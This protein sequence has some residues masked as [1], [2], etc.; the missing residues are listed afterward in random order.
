[1]YLAR[2]SYKVSTL[3]NI[4]NHCLIYLLMGVSS[5]PV[6]FGNEFLIAGFI[7]TLII[8]YLKTKRFDRVVLTYSLVFL[9][10]FIVHTLA[11][12]QFVLDTFV[13]YFM[14]IYFAYFTVKIIG[15]D[16]D[17]Y[18]IKQIYFFTIISLIVT[19]AIFAYTPL[20]DII[21]SSVTPVFD[22]ITLYKPPEP[23]PHFIIYTMDL[24]YKVELPRNSGPFWEPGGFSVFLFLALTFNVVRTRKIVNTKNIIFFIAIL[25]TQ[26]TTAYLAVFVASCI[27]V[28]ISYRSIYLF[29]V[30]PLLIVIFMNLYTRL[31]FLEEK[32]DKMY[33]ESKKAGTD[34]INSRIVS[35]KVNMD[36]FFSSPL[37]GIGRFFE[38][39]FEDNTGN[40]G[41]TL[42]LA[43]FGL[44]GFVYYF[45]M[46]LLSYKKYCKEHDYNIRF[47]YVVVVGL[48]ILGYS[49]GI[50]QKPFFMALC[51]M[52]L[53]KHKPRELFFYRGLNE[54]LLQFNTS[55]QIVS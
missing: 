22:K 52:F 54:R 23:K 1:M 17:K 15:K 36:N 34:R 7:I 31:T 51:F 47:A 19:G 42:L 53:V 2:E 4:L 25:T 32:I 13:A 20:A 46:M 55:K 14:R 8:F 6:L 40:N 30:M 3:D 48:L 10:L 33:S 21:Y 37:F 24:G 45:F 16:I 18:F 50:F 44:I 49:Q 27:Y 39:K 29:I 26:S 9:G 11:F 5:I 38:V 28:L 43:E 35:G 12:N 41:T